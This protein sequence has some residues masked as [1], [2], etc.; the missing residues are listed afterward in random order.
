[1]NRRFSLSVLFLASAVIFGSFISSTDVHG[2]TPPSGESATGTILCSVFPVFALAKEIASGASL[3]VELLLPAD[4]GCPHQY[5][6][7]PGD[8]RRI[9]QARVLIL[10]G[11]RFEPFLERLTQDV[12]DLPRIV[13]A[14][15]VF[16]IPSV[17]EPDEV[18]AHVFTTPSGLRNMGA[19]MAS[20]LAILDPSQADLYK[21]NARRFEARLDEIEKQFTELAV[22]TASVPV[23]L[24]H[25]SLDYLAKDLHLRV[26]ARLGGGGDGESGEVS[27]KRMAEVSELIRREKPAAILVDGRETP[28][29]AAT[30]VRETGI[31]LIHLPLLT[32]GESSPSADYMY[33]NLLEIHGLLSGLV[34]D[35]KASE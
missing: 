5:S 20:Q 18:N 13:C 7:T 27:A 24:T 35:E 1:M 4:L 26:L 33:R 32:S 25:D 21:K 11:L 29:M 34:S 23:L 30:L 16:T 6:L 3:P 22:K 17:D 28:P 12:P 10:N 2:A 15:G 8:F 14:S 9:T 31:R 19:N